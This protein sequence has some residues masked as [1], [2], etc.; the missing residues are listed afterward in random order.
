MTSLHAAINILHI[1]LDAGHDSS[2]DAQ[3]ERESIEMALEVLN[4]EQPSA[5]LIA[6]AEHHSAN[7]HSPTVYYAADGSSSLIVSGDADSTY[8][9]S[10]TEEG[11]TSSANTE[12]WNTGY[13][14]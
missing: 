7:F 10:V 8:I 1:I 13:E 6:E 5:K 3:E 2:D 4:R 9:V 12:E 11:N 14:L